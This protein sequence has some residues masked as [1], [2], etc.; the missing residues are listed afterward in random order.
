ML[1]NS[2][3]ETK[4]IHWPSKKDTPT[5]TE[6]EADALMDNEGP[7]DMLVEAETLEFD[8]ILVKAESEIFL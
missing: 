2:P 8:G 5:L 7:A 1:L 6:A 4:F 3:K